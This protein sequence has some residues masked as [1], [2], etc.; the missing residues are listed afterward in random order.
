MCEKKS[1][2]SLGGFCIAFP[3]AEYRVKH[4]VITVR[5]KF[6]S[7]ILLNANALGP[8]RLIGGP[9]AHGD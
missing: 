4:A 5:F 7:N 6:V 1:T 2:N 9:S 8:D 3:L